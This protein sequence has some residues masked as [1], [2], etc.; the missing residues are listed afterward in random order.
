MPAKIVQ[1]SIEG[2]F[3]LVGNSFTDDRGSFLNCFRQQERSFLEAWNSREI[4]QINISKTS[5]VGTVRGLHLQKY[6]HSEAKLIRCIRG[7]VWDVAVDLRRNSST[8]CKWHAV[9]LDS[10]R[11]NAVVIPEGCAHGFQVLEPDSELLYMHSQHWQPDAEAG[12]CWNDSAL[13]IAWPL[14]VIMMSQRDQSL[15]C[16][17]AFF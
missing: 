10:D 4:M 5:Q 15:P 2:V 8:F 9:E 16:I 14:P 17:E 3:E 7:K 11:C 12:V 6:P 1:S 13:S